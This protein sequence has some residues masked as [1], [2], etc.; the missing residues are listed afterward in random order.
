MLPFPTFIWRFFLRRKIQLASFWKQSG[1]WNFAFQEVH[2][3]SRQNTRSSFS[4]NRI[5]QVNFSSQKKIIKWKQIKITNMMPNCLRCCA[6]LSRIIQINYLKEFRL[7]MQM[8]SPNVK[9]F[10]LFFQLTSILVPNC[11]N[12]KISFNMREQCS[13]QRSGS[14]NAT[15][16]HCQNNFTWLVISRI[17][18]S[19]FEQ[20]HIISFSGH[21]VF[22]QLE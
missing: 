3:F 2:T 13:N 22:K 10:C 12:F 18:P 8:A 17:V 4:I 5:C 11:N 16:L 7:E 20:I 14:K 1:W 15:F 21:L 6:G 19:K 9:W